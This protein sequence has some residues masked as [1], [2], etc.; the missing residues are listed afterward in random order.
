MKLSSPPFFLF[1]VRSYWILVISGRFKAF[2][3]LE[4]IFVYVNE[5]LPFIRQF[6]FVKYGIHW[7]GVYAR[8]AVYAFIRMY[9]QLIISLI[10]AVNR[11][12]LDTSLV[13]NS[14]TWFGNYVCHLLNLRIGTSPLY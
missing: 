5:F 8:S 9:D 6:I 3:A 11:A 10:Y 7:T 14:D 13:L 1:K 2:F 4:E 12:R